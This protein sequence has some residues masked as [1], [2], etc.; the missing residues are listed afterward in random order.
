MQTSTGSREITDHCDPI[1]TLLLLRADRGAD[2]HCTPLSR[3]LAKRL[4][5]ITPS[6]SPW[7]AKQECPSGPCD[8]S[9]HTLSLDIWSFS[10]NLTC[11]LSNLCCVS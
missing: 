1:I 5:N 4:E 11:H 7:E 10:I 6:I 3:V 9:H 2:L 8:I